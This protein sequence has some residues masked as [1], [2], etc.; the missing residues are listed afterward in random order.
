LIAFI[1]M[2]PSENKNSR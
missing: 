1:E 2:H